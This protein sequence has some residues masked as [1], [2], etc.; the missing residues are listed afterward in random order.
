MRIGPAILTSTFAVVVLI[1]CSS[2][3]DKPADV[4]E[5]TQPTTAASTPT[6]PQTFSSVVDLRDAAVDA[7]YECRRWKQTN[8][9]TLAAESGTCSA[10]SVLSTYASDGD[11][12]QQLDVDKEM[13]DLLTD[14]GIETTPALVGPNWILK[15][16]RAADLQ[17]A[18]G[19]V[20]VGA[21]S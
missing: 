16:P 2:G 17:D 9:V 18:L 6:G 15:D 4:E 7:G 11:L 12:Q 10:A 20:V 5:P 1:G 14:S 13:A 21:K 3:S 8:D 19:G